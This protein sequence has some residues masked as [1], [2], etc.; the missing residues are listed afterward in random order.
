MRIGFSTV[1]RS[2]AI[3][4]AT[5]CML[6]TTGCI[7]AGS[8]A[9][10]GQPVF[11]GFVGSSPNP[12]DSTDTGSTGFFD[13]GS[14]AN[15][16]PCAES[17][18]R[19]F[20]RISMRNETP[21]AYIHYFF[22]AVAFVNGDVYPNGAVCPDDI[23]LYTSFGYAE[24]AEGESQPFGTYCFD[25]PALV[26]FHKSGQFRS[27]GGTA[28]STFASAIPPALGTSPTYDNFFTSA[29]VSVPVP[30][31]I[32]WHNP[33]TGEGSALK[34]S[35]NDVG[36]CDIVISTFGVP[37]CEQDAFYYVDEF[38]LMSGSVALGAGSGRRVPNEIQGTGCE[39]GAFVNFNGRS[40]QP[41]QALAPS[42]ASSSAARCN[43][44]L[45]GG[46]IEYVFARED[47]NPPFPQLLWRTTDASGGVANDFDSRGPGQ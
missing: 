14:R 17:N 35:R 24:I 10:L 21:D 7:S 19:K 2:A 37:D 12:G 4:S 16:D 28:N 45:R 31:M 25:G 34:I 41:A 15:L 33:G 3:A 23:P 46:F 38:D 13:T 27:G 36:P 5:A 43:E 8:V 40:Y 22:V 32:L 30:N 47:T 39:C 44:Y 11:N 18:S 6:W 29:G 1:A 9:L 20:V 26:Y 42:S